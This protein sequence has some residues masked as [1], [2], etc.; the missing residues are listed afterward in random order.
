MNRAE[1]IVTL[2]GGTTRV[3]AIA[4]VHR[5][6]VWNWTKPRERGGTGGVIPQKHI[7]PLLDHARQHGIPLSLDDFLPPAEA[8][9]A[10]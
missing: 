1:R 5:T 7:R 8:E 4:G 10:A 9:R 3:A 6:R 2:L